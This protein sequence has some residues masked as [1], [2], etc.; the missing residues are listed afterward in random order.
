[1]KWLQR[2]CSFVNLG[3]QI[4]PYY[5]TRIED[6][7]GNVIENFVPK[8]KQALDEQTAYKMIFMLQGGVQEAGGTHSA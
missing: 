2:I 1:M 7:N 6:K 4:E 5:L 8:T 3:I